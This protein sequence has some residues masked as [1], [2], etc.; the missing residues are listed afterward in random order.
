VSTG[1]ISGSVEIQVTALVRSLTC[2]EVENVP[3][4]R[5]FPVPCKLRT[6]MLD[7]IMVSESIGSGAAVAVTVMVAG[8][9]DTTVPSGF[10]QIAVIVVEPALNP[11][12]S[13]EETEAIVGMLEF[14]VT[15]FELVTFSCRPVVPET[16]SAI[17]W[18][19]CPDADNNS[20]VGVM[21]SAVRGSLVPPVTV[22]FA[23][24]VAVVP[25]AAFV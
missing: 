19:V 16:P 2:G 9:A 25:S 18:L 7:G 6:L 11:V 21:E 24:P 20:E 1:K 5:K 8:D 17:S 22:K 23:W 12:T 15:C 4:A 14:H 10:V 13:P 3:I